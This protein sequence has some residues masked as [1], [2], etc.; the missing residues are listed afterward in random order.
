[1]FG[2]G[3]GWISPERCLKIWTTPWGVAGLVG[4]WAFSTKVREWTC[5]EDVEPPEID[6]STMVVEFGPDGVWVTEK[7]GRFLQG[8]TQG[9]CAWGSGRIPALA[10]LYMGADARRAVEVAMLLDPGCG[11]DVYELRL[12]EVD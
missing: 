12:G 10:A 11:G 7:G 5:S 4:S 3:D 6:D 1:M 2:G 8:M 9:F